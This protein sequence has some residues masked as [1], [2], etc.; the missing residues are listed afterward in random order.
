MS[1]NPEI[2]Q[3][4]NPSPI[5]AA[6]DT[7]NLRIS[8][9]KEDTSITSKGD[10]ES[11]DIDENGLEEII[12]E[13]EQEEAFTDESDELT[14][15]KY[16]VGNEGISAVG[17]NARVTINNYIQIVR[18]S[19]RRASRDED[20]TSDD[21]FGEKDELIEQSLMF[22]RQ[23]DTF[24]INSIDKNE[25]TQTKLPEK[26]EQISKWYYELDE[27]E[28]CYVQAAA[29]LHGAP[30]HE[31][32]NRADS[33]FSILLELEGQRSSTLSNTHTEPLHIPSHNKSSRGLQAKTL[34]ITQRVEGVERLFWRDVD[35]Y[36]IS[37]FGLRLLDFLAGE[38]TS[39]GTQGRYLRERLQEWSKELN[40]EA[41]WRSVRAL[42]VFLWHQNVEELRRVATLWVKNKG[43][44]NWRRTAMLLDSAYEI[45][46]IKD[47][48][49]V[50]NARKSSVLQLLSEWVNRSQKMKFA[51]DAYM[52]CGAANTYGLIGKR[53]P[54]VALHELGQLLQL[55]PDRPI[56][57]TDALFAVIISA[58]I[59]LSWSGHLE[60][61]LAHLACVAKQSVLQLQRPARISERHIYRKQCEMKLNVTLETFFLIIA[62][63]LSEASSG[64]SEAY[65]KPL[66]KQPSFPDP[67]GRDVVLAG[68]LTQDSNEWREQVTALL[69][70]AII[71]G[72]NRS[73]AFEV[74]QQ[75]GKLVVKMQEEQSGE[76]DE[77]CVSFKQFMVS[78]GKCIDSWCLDIERRIG[79]S[80][81]SGIIYRNRLEYWCKREG[82][83]SQLSHDVLSLLNS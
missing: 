72:R 22:V 40:Q 36:G 49:T 2:L 41:S 1:D 8:S 43:I 6:A 18:E 21:V 5:L 67:L 38:F 58:Y 55:P 62:D 26:E 51:T 47:P 54:E 45:E 17:D 57:E 56:S 20:G 76:A 35:I 25:D 10:Q 9:T 70:T 13:D 39:K 31:V 75:W 66:P 44:R 34:T 12:D 59:S 15:A 77:L 23:S 68:L 63:S 30:A 24:P 69:C 27:Y 64:T 14:E 50:D 16:K 73:S 79:R 71:E 83:F 65:K 42:G 82:R 19:R 11:E 74:I 33:L 46:G 48:E 3:S 80:P 61:V 29:I 52:G 28:Q 81:L 53:N 60:S 32:S 78:L 37:S 7:E 4:S